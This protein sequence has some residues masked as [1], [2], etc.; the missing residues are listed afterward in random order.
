VGRGKVAQ[1]KT[2]MLQKESRQEGILGRIGGK[3]AAPQEKV[4]ALQRQPTEPPRAT[5][6]KKRE[7]RIDPRGGKRLQREFSTSG[8]RKG[9][10]DYPRRK[11][12]RIS[13]KRE[14]EEEILMREGCGWIVLGGLS[15]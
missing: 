6:I 15:A 3:S 12:A 2:S 10:E 1:K 14:E 4:S 7:R 8:E 11:K 13:L 5:S 9:N